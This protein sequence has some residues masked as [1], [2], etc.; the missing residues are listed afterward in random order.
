VLIVGATGNPN[1]P[2][3]RSIAWAPT[4]WRSR[5][6]RLRLSKVMQVLAAHLSAD[7]DLVTG[8]EQELAYLGRS[9]GQLDLAGYP[10]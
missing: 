5:T 2:G 8:R 10:G 9:R 7:V 6:A 4:I 3:I 1:Q